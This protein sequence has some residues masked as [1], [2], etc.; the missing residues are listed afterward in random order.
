MRSI[1]D[2]RGLWIDEG[3]RFAKVYR[4]LSK[5][6]LRKHSLPTIFN[7]KITCLTKHLKYHRKIEQSVEDPANFTNMKDY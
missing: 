7:S 4:I 3:N 1:P 2:L 5:E 6:Y